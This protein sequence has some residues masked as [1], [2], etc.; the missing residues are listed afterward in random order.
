MPSPTRATRPPWSPAADGGDAPGDAT[1]AEEDART[2]AARVRLEEARVAYVAG[3]LGRGDAE[4]SIAV[5]LDQELAAD[6]VAIME[7]TLGG[8]PGSERLLLYG[9][10]LRAA[11]R[12]VEADRAYDRAVGRPG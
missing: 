6:G 4:M 1:P 7:P 9:D 12:R 11:G 8:K 5:R 10:L 2:A 3:D